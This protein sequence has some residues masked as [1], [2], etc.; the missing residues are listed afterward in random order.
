LGGGVK[1]GKTE[2][3][4][5]DK[6]L[7]TLWSFTIGAVGG[8]EHQKKKGNNE[9]KEKKIQQRMVRKRMGREVGVIGSGKSAGK[10]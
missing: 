10:Q 5:R 8:E 9:L 2:K 7:K 6:R 3:T 4:A 1:G